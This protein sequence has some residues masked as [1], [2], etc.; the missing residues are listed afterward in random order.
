METQLLDA[1]LFASMVQAGAANLG[2]NRQI[3]NDLNVFP[4]PDGDTG[5]NMYMTMD[6]G[7][8]ELQ[9]TERSCSLGDTAAQAAK[10]MLLGAR[11]NSGVI[12]SRIFAGIAHGLSGVEKADL[13]TFSRAFSQGVEEAYRAVS[14]PVEGTILTVYKEAVAYASGRMTETSSFE[15]FFFDFLA[16][17]HSSLERTPQLLA[18]LREAGVVD[19]GGAGFIYIAEGMKNALT[20]A[21]SPSDAA[22]QAAAQGPDVSLF[23]EDSELTFGYCTEFLLRLQRSKVDLE[24][25]DL[26][27]ILDWLNQVGESVVCFRDGSVV[28]VHV[29]TRTPGDILNRMQRYGEFLT[30]KIENMT[31]QHRETQIQNRYTPPVQKP[32]KAYGIVTVASGK[33]IKDIFVR[34]GCDA[35]VEGGQSM[36]P[37]AEDFVRAFDSLNAD[38]ILVFPNNGN[39]ILTAR[40]AAELYDKARVCIV[41]TRTVGEGYAAVSMLDTSSGDTDEI[42]SS[43]EEIIGGVVTGFVAP[44][45]RAAQKD[46][47]EI[48]PG[49]SIGFVGDR[50]YVDAHERSRALVALAH[51]L[52]AGRYD[53]ALLLWGRDV[54]AG[55]AEA[56]QAELAAAFPDTEVILLEGDQP[57]YEYILIL[58]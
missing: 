35:V 53:V 13:P 19:S 27:E 54:P 9:G 1:G 24:H 16:E 6:S 31:L 8:A 28:K 23:T 37:S 45:S 25:F 58:E 51:A 7:A 40:Q 15:S 34:L 43:L 30:L 14:V 2:A 52:D 3:V 22:P 50:V 12:L 11:G 21:Q 20:G 17:L 33:G 46:G 10:G 26:N 44:A 42:V 18:V 39:V 41:P 29:H 5:D 48:C 56:L 32:H 55:E 36:N 4:I 57:L 49:D 47:V 38:T